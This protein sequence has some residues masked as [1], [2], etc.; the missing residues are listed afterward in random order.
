M[1]LDNSANSSQQLLIFNLTINSSIM[2]PTNLL[3]SQKAHHRSNLSPSESYS[4]PSLITFLLLPLHLCIYVHGTYLTWRDVCYLIKR[5]LYFLHVFQFTYEIH[6]TE[7]T[8]MTICKI[9]Q[10]WCTDLFWT[11]GSVISSIMSMNASSPKTALQ[12][13]LG[14]NP[15]LYKTDLRLMM[16]R[17][18]Y[19]VVCNRYHHLFQ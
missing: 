13:S 6:A 7:T 5:P 16:Y 17:S 11:S 18:Q 1:I 12:S 14:T 2:E 15:F 10:H 4:S 8:V 9:W 3:P 19:P